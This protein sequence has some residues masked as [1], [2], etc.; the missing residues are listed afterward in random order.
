MERWI[1][2]R[3]WETRVHAQLTLPKKAQTKHIIK[4]GKITNPQTMKTP[5]PVKPAL[6]NG[7]GTTKSTKK[8]P[9]RPAAQEAATTAVCSSRTENEEA[10]TKNEEIPA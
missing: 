5:L 4:V 2:A 9:E 8:T 10:N 1:A 3:P 7:K 6:S